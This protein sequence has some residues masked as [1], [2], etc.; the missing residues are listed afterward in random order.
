MATF[1]NDLRLKEI[2]TGD[3]SGN[4]GN[5][6]NTNLELIAEAFSFG[7]EA[8]TTNADTHSTEI[9][10]G[11]TDPGRSIFLKY[12]GTLDSACTITIGPNT[13]SKLWFIENATSGS[14]N[15][16]IKQGSGATVTIANGQTKAIYSDGAGSGGA[17]VDA[18]T[19]LSVPSFFVSGDLDVD[20]TTNLDVVDIDSTLT[21]NGDTSLTGGSSGSTVL[22]LTSNALADTPLM[23]FQRTGGAIAGKLAYE[24]TNTAMSFG[25]TTAHELKLLTSN[26]SRLEIISG[27]SVGIGVTPS[28]GQFEVLSA[29]N[30]IVA[31]FAHPSSSTST[32]NGGAVVN[33][34]NTNSTNGN[35]SSVIFR[36]SNNNA[37]SGIFGYNSDHSDGEGLMTFGTRDSS[38][39]FG[40]RMR[41]NSSGRLLHGTST[42]PTGVLLGNQLVSSS[43]TGSEIIAFRAD[44]SVAVDDITG[45]FLLGNSD[46]DGT[47]DHFVGMYGKVSSTNGSQNVHFVAG[48]AGYE[49]DSPDLT[50]FSGGDLSLGTTSPA[51]ESKLHVEVA[52][53]DPN[54]GSPT[55]S[56]A[57]MVNGGTSFTGAGPVLALRNISGSKE[58]IVRFCAETTG[59]NN[60]DLTISTYGGGATVD[61]AVRVTGAGFVGVG[62]D[63]PGAILN[64]DCG[65]P[66]SSDKTLGLFQS[67]TSR[68]IGFVWDD[69]SSTLG[70]ATLTN[71]PLAF[72]TNGNSGE[73]ARIRADNGISI[74]TTTELGSKSNTARVTGGRFITF[75]DVVGAS[76]GSATTLV[77]FDTGL[78][79]Y[80]VS[81]GL[82]GANNASIYSATAIVH[83]DGS[84]N[85][86]LTHL[87]NPSNMTLSLS[88]LVLSG[89]QTSGATVNISFS[90]IRIQ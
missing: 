75:G 86:T 45:A 52:T 63:S 29:S 53:S 1:V 79:V 36:D 47:E 70:V 57:L 2:A 14:Q 68:Q 78:G 30:Q 87:V 5:V 43:A 15:I 20:G 6:T 62:T 33:V 56:S 80:L 83:I 32:N 60:G 37:S 54:S 19:D 7:T 28:N 61:E 38:G 51:D 27:G 22:T 16:I 21:V 89:T 31:H 10:D 12:T 59:N 65:A 58:T 9:Q 81:A 40:E 8:I 69:S 25:T 50:L 13:V 39:G 4:W 72:H 67:Q 26:T 55:A 18:F 71:H 23:V 66:S 82:S 48:R 90:M 49:G 3:E 44:T 85:N 74:G 34:Q 42:V 41:I 88:G 35:M 24:D 77:T 46:T 84:S 64:V 17:M 76:S 11:G 73:R